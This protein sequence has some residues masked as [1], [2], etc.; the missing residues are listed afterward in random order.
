MVK[1]SNNR[2][3][4]MLDGA[5]IWDDATTNFSE[6]FQYSTS[7]ALSFGRT[8]GFQPTVT[9]MWDMTRI[10]N[11]AR[12]S[13]SQ[14]FTPPTTMFTNDDN[15]WYLSSFENTWTPAPSPT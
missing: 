4:F 13:P 12:Y 1:E 10:S 9:T 8:L 6:T 15:T 3:F 14:T 5:T 2:R 7:P 11:I